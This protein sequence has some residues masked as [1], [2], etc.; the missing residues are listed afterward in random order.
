MS[1][2]ITIAPETKSDLKNYVGKIISDPQFNED[3][4]RLVARM[5][6][7]ELGIMDVVIYGERKDG[8]TLPIDPASVASIVKGANL[9]F[10][11]RFDIN[12]TEKDGKKYLNEHLVLTSWAAANLPTYEVTGKV[13]FGK[14][15]TGPQ[16]NATKEE[17]RKAFQFQIARY[18][19][20]DAN[21]DYRP[22]HFIDVVYFGNELPALVT[23]G[24]NVKITGKLESNPRTVEVDGKQVT[25]YNR[26]VVAFKIEAN[27][28]VEVE[29]DDAGNIISSGR[30]ATT[31]PAPAAE[32][33]GIPQYEPQPQEGEDLPF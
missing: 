18:R 9:T 24:A 20:K 4:T 31:A 7:A 8:K 10:S 21:G 23:S 16:V 14:D 5:A 3:K 15:A 17:S 13:F 30:A 32:A 6:C 2:I 28:P 26:R 33:A 29:V 22:S 11:A 1:R 27:N 25:Y 12:P 19:G